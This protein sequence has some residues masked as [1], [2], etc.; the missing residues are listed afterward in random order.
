M[1]T[2][3]NTPLYQVS[4]LKEPH[5][6]NSYSMTQELSVWLEGNRT[7][8]LTKRLLYYRVLFGH[9]DI[10]AHF[11][12]IPSS[13]NFGMRLCTNLHCVITH[14]LILICLRC[15]FIQ[16]V[17]FKLLFSDVRHNGTSGAAQD[18][19]IR[20]KKYTQH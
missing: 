4:K 16:F 15:L 13:E 6:T 11:C 10:H 5:V 19:F 18:I 17:Q 14:V 20:T 12:L 8:T 2:W 1:L 9:V 7:S 3:E